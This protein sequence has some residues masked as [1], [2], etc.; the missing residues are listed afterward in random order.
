[1]CFK[2][3]IVDLNDTVW[4]YL[5][6]KNSAVQEK[7]DKKSVKYNAIGHILTF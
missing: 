3:N 6:H 5:T 2:L 1:M 4:F 7:Q